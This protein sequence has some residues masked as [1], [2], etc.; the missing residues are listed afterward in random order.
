LEC[1]GPAAAE[2]LGQLAVEAQVLMRMRTHDKQLLL[3]SEKRSGNYGIERISSARGNS[4][5]EIRRV[6]DEDSNRN[7]STELG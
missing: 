1:F 4:P 2:I 3:R 5:T 6:E 7:Q